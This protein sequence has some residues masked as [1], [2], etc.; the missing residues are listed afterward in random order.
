V[1]DEWAARRLKLEEEA[2]EF[3]DT[4]SR[5]DGRWAHNDYMVALQLQA[6]MAEQETVP[7]SRECTV[8]G[9]DVPIPQLPALM[10]CIHEP[11]VCAGCFASWIA[12]ALDSKGWRHIG[13]PESNC[14]TMLDHVEVQLYAAPEVFQKYLLPSAV[15]TSNTAN[16]LFRFDALSMRDALN[17]DPDFRWCL[18]PGCNSGQIHDGAVDDPRSVCNDCGFAVCIKHERAWH[19]GETCEEYDYRI[20]GRQQR[21]QAAEEAASE[22]E[23]NRSSKKCPGRNCAYNIQKN[24]GCDHM[25]CK[26][27]SSG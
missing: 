27:F 26:L 10:N 1:S 12:S 19:E 14:R 18:R 15:S 13:C 22:A 17:D 21:D 2:R 11:K 4:V 16:A 24:E 20:S 9:D 25:T 5:D 7:A 6:D 23:I 8:C 3:Y